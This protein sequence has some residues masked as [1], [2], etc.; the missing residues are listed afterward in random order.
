MYISKFDD[1]IKKTVFPYVIFIIGT[2]RSCSFLSFLRHTH[3]CHVHI[4]HLA[5]PRTLSPR[6]ATVVDDDDLER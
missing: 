3:A 6:A 1:A 2:Y 4:T 5:P